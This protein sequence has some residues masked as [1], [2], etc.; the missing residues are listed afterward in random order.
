LGVA[1]VK[2][3]GFDGSQRLC[4]WVRAIGWELVAENLGIMRH[5]LAHQ[6]GD[7]G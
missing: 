2:S 3:K 1:G 6:T 5:D 4:H 7:F